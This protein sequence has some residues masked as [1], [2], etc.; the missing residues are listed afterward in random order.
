MYLLLHIVPVPVL[1]PVPLY[2]YLNLHLHLY[3][4]MYL[5]LCL[6]LWLRHCNWTYICP[7]AL[8]ACLCLRSWKRI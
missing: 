1:V 7:V 3:L 6:D 2:P 4:Y 5:F 8:S